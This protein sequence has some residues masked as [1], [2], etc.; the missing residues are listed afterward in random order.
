[1]FIFF[2]ICFV[3]VLLI[4]LTGAHKDTA[5]EGLA[6]LALILA[7]ID[8]GVAMLIAPLPG[9]TKDEIIY[10]KPVPNQE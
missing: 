7:L 6:F 10:I 9:V 8:C 2:G 1:M 4:I 3:I 5:V